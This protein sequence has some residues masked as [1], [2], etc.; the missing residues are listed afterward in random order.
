MIF[1]QHTNKKS[2]GLTSVGEDMK[3]REC[4]QI[5]KLVGIFYKIKYS[6]NLW[7]RGNSIP[8]DSSLEKSYKWVPGD[9]QKNNHR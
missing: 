6:H 7:S 2:L 8:R 3:E 4:K 9:K 5:Q 1:T